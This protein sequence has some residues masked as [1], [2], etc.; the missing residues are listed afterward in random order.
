LHTADVYQMPLATVY[1]KLTH[2]NV[3]GGDHGIFHQGVP[4]ITGNGTDQVTWMG[5][6]TTCTLKL[7]ALDANSTKVAASCGKSDSSADGADVLS[8]SSGQL[9][10]RVIEAVDATLTGRAYDPDRAE[11]GQ[12]AANWPADTVDHATAGEVVNNH[13]KQLPANMAAMNN[14]T[15]NGQPMQADVPGQPTLNDAPQNNR[16]TVDTAPSLQTN[17]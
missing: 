10:N 5:R 8:W 16:P 6:S 2:A 14:D 9:R 3:S 13:L 4:T 12:T 1:D 17:P 7:S 11:E 15:T